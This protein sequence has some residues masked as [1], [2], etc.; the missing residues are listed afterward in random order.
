MERE[1]TDEISLD[2]RRLPLGEETCQ[3]KN[4]YET[5]YAQMWNEFETQFGFLGEKL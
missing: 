5:E 3:R 1:E 2:T 4:P